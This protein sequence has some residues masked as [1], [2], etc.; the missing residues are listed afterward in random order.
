MERQTRMRLGITLGDVNGIG[1][2]LIIKTFSDPYMLELCTP[3]IYG[4]PKIIAYYRKALNIPNFNP[5]TI[6]SVDELQERKVNMVSCVNDE[7]RVE[8]GQATRQGGEAA[9]ASLQAAVEDLKLGKIDGVVTAPINKATI[10][11]DV[12]HFPGHTEYLCDAFGVKEG[13]MLMVSDIVK[14]GVVTGHIPLSEVPAKITVEAILSKLRLMNQCLKEDFGVDRPK[15]AVLSLNPHAGEQGL[16]GQEEQTVIIPAIE[17]AMESDVYAFGPFPSDGFFG[18][19]E[20]RKYDAVLAMYHDQGL[21]PFK[22]MGFESGV[23]YTAG[24]PIIRTSP[25]H[26]TAYD[27]AGKNLASVESFRQAVYVACDAWKCRR[28]YAFLKAHAMKEVKVSRKFEIED[29]PEAE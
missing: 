2:E 10:Q 22:A 3:V 26:G 9:L 6:R 16:L 24:L 8:L 5:V 15:I 14:L 20:F 12:F 25:A 7:I 28:E 19:G 23:N 17:M 29:N 4:S 1:C 27:L 11:S 13:L 18:S 21:T